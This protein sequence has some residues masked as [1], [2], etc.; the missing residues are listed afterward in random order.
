MSFLRPRFK[1]CCIQNADEARLAIRYGASAVGL[2]SAM[3]S[4]P[5]PIDDERIASIIPHIPPGI[6]SFL[7][8]S[9]QDAA[10]IVAQQKRLRPSTLQLVDSVSTETYH[11]LRKELPGIRIVQVIHVQGKESVHEVIAVSSFVDAILLDS[12]SP[13]LPVKELGGTG[14]RRIG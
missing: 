3:P 11:A 12:G 2:V 9:M 7:L 6:D 13:S 4:G 1:I 10:E 5:G 14:R 8:T